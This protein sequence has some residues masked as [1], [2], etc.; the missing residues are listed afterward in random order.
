M[1]QPETQSAA[2]SRSREN[3]DLWKEAPAWRNLTLVAVGLTVAATALTLP[4]PTQLAPSSAGPAAQVATRAAP[5]STPSSGGGL[6]H[7]QDA[8]PPSTPTTPPAVGAPKLAQPTHASP[9]PIQTANLA[10]SGQ[11]PQQA[12]PGQPTVQPIGAQQPGVCLLQGSP[13]PHDLGMGTVTAFEDRSAS[14]ARIQLT[15]ANTK[16][17]IDPAYIDNLRVVVRMADGPARVILVPKSM[18]VQL[19]DRVMVQTGYRNLN[20]PCNYI[21]NLITADIG[22]VQQ[23]QSAPPPPPPIQP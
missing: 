21:P 3:G 14:M 1:F 4:S 19:G 7:V 9:A 22:P 6:A 10:P 5:P 20:L 18:T 23:A 12:L 8:A 11:G 17:M 16:G 13:A 15:Q 2:Q